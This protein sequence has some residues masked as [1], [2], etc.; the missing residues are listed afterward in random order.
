[1]RKFINKKRLMSKTKSWLSLINE[2]K[3]LP[4]SLKEKRRVLSRRD[5]EPFL[6]IFRPKKP[7]LSRFERILE[8]LWTKSIHT[9]IKLRQPRKI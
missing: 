4:K 1:M 2:R 6:T 9:K 7:R 5:K 8:P 3:S